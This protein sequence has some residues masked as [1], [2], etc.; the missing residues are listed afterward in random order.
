VI[1]GLSDSIVHTP[2]RAG[3]VLVCLALGTAALSAAPAV[4]S[5]GLKPAGYDS[6]P[7]GDD[8]TPAGDDSTPGGD[9]TQSDL[10]AFMHQVLAKRDENWKKLQQYVL[11]ERE[12]LDAKA[13]NEAPLF[14]QRRLY[15]WFIRDGYFVRSPVSVNGAP[16]P[17]AERAR[18]EDDYL[19]RAKERE[20]R[21]DD[22]GPGPQAVGA[23]ANGA[24]AS[25]TQAQTATTVAPSEPIAPGM[26]SIVLQTGQPEFINAAYFLR[27]KFESGHYGLVGREKLDGVDVLR[28][29]YYPARLFSRTTENREKNADSAADRRRE[30]EV[31]R[32]MNRNSL[33][34]LWVEP[35][36]KQIVKYEFDNIQLDFLPAAWL[37]RLDDL[38]ASMTM[39]Q[40]FKDVWLPRDVDLALKM[41]FAIGTIAIRYRLE[42]FDY[43]E[44]KTSG[45]IRGIVGAGRGGG[46]G[47][48]R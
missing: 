12:T 25:Q 4:G 38:K 33:V 31:E 34:T 37:V 42:Y 7:A 32:L 41:T 22:N 19:R 13:P 23:S 10:D 47:G 9:I 26:E 11:D 6:T 45:R 28:I 27:F 2:G 8:S 18:L 1:R 24:A 21:G 36:S 43:Q 30:L 44:A 5:G 14:G 39:G 29:E 3:R 40:P 16:V 15:R 46:G 48:A 20:K 35:A 17:D